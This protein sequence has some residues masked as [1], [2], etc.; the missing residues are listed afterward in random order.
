MQPTA[1]EP[2]TSRAYCLAVLTGVAALNQLDR[3]LMSILLEPVRR[4][5]ALSDIQLGLLSGLAFAALY[6]T[7]SIPAAVWAVSHSRRNLIAAAAVVWGVMT[8]LCGATHSFAQHLLARLGVGLGEAGGI[9]PS[10]AM[11][12]DL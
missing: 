7:L 4:E 6:T 9:P 1:E 3:Q 10:H 2:A 12:S 8:A 5:F 11:I